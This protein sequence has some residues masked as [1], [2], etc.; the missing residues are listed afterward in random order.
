MKSIL[1][2]RDTEYKE[3]EGDE[4]EMSLKQFQSR[5]GWFRGGQASRLS[6][7][8][9]GILAARLV[10]RVQE[11]EKLSQAKVKKLESAITD[12]YKRRFSRDSQK[13]RPSEQGTREEVLKA[14]RELLG[15]KGMAALEAAL[16]QGSRPQPK[17]K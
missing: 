16:S 4:R 11:K 9:A 15:E 1:E 8:E 14:G 6:E 13:G 10:R 2:P 5:N 3:L 17:D 12:I 7:E